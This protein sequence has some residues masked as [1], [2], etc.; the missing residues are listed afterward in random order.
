MEKIK[1][2]FMGV[3][4]ELGRVRW[5]NKK[6]IITYSIATISFIFLFACFFTLADLII[7]GIRMA[8]K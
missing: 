8:V 3:K 5:P 6:E 4:K 1:G 2:F 7:A